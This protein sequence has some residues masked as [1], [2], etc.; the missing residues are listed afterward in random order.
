M[1]LI[2]VTLDWKVFNLATVSIVEK[3][4]PEGVIEAIKLLGGV[5]KFF[6]PEDFVLIKPNVCGGV[7]GK[8]GTFTSIEVISG[9]TSVL[10]GKVSRIGIG[11]SDSSMYDADRMLKENKIIDYSK[12]YGL[13][14]INLSKGD[15]EEFPVQDGYVLES[16]KVSKIMNKVSKIISAPIAKTHTTTQVTLNLKNMIGLLPQRKKGQ[17]HKMIDPMLSDIVKTF[18]P[19]LCVVDAI[20]GLEG[21]GPFHGDPIR[22]DLIVAGDNAV[23]TDAVMAKIMGFDPKKIMHLRLASE[24]GIGPINLAEIQVLGLTVKEVKTEFKKSMQ[25]PFSRSLSRIPGLGHI[26][27]HYGYENAV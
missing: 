5:D 23:A 1:N 7:P 21:F 27:V 10:K 18:P 24:A 6:V 16:I 15:I 14:V 12:K 3:K 22:L 13:D 2:I 8:V 26:F 19:T 20:V 25:E 17:L 11:E 9:I 4:A